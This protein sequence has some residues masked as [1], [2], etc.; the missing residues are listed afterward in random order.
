M[1]TSAANN[2][3]SAADPLE[4]SRVSSDDL[5]TLVSA[6]GSCPTLTPARL[7]GQVMAASQFSGQP[8]AAM[9]EVGGQGPAALTTQVWAKWAPWQGAQPTDREASIVAL[10]HDMCQLVGQVRVVKIDGDQWDLALAAHRT[11]MEAVVSAGAVPDSTQEYVD[12]VERYAAWYALQ[13]EFGGSGVAAPT[14]TT[15]PQVVEDPVVPVPDALVPA[16]VAAGKVCPEMPPSRIAAQVMATSGF[17]QQKLGPTGEQGIAQFLPQ[18]W[19]RYVPPSDSSTPW[20][21]KTALPALGKTMCALVKDDGEYSTALATFTQGSAAADTPAVAKLAD[22]VERDAT[23]Y[24]KDARL[25][26]KAPSATPHSPSPDASTSTLADGKAPVAGATT[27]GTTTATTKPAK[28]SSKPAGDQPPVKGSGSGASYGP[29]FIYDS[30]TTQCFDIPGYGAGPRDGP[31]N[32]APC[33]KTAPDNQKYAFVPRGK[34]AN[35]NQEYWIRSVTDNYCV[36]P[37]GTGAAAP[38]SQLDETGCFDQDNQYFRLQPTFSSG[39]RQYYWIVNTASGLCVDVTGVK[40]TA[41]DT[42]LALWTCT[43]GDDQDW[44][45]VKKW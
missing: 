21:P 17:D 19:V 10:A 8:V 14:A 37:P 5:R 1:A 36:D 40:P 24:A 12:T 6:A 18:T 15:D 20:D 16:V 13:P 38:E 11:S 44:A 29:Y 7:A 28:A 45:L 4:G 41:P 33:A 26:V 3:A 27:P 42:R 31:V 30:A 22:V 43:E 35:G 2:S 32:Q 39:G 23:E 25:Q 34:D 9:K